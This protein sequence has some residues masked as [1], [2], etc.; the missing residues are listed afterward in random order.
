[1]CSVDPPDLSHP[2]PCPF[3]GPVPY[4]EK[5]RHLFRG[6][7]SDLRILEAKIEQRLVLLTGPS[8]V[9]KSSLLSAAL[10]P[11]LRIRRHQDVKGGGDE[12]PPILLL[13]SWAGG[14]PQ[15]DDTLLDGIR[16]AV[17]AFSQ[18]LDHDDQ[19]A[20]PG[21]TSEERP[22]YSREERQTFRDDLESLRQIAA[23]GSISELLRRVRNSPAGRLT[24]I[25]DQ[26]EE[27]LQGSRDFSQRLQE[28]VA[29]LYE[30]SVVEVVLSYRE[31]ARERLSHLSGRIKDRLDRQQVFLLP[32]PAA[33]VEQALREVITGTD[34]GGSIDP[35]EDRELS[36]LG[37]LID[38]VNDDEYGGVDLLTLQALLIDI[39][40]T[41]D[42][43]QPF[44]LDRAALTSLLGRLGVGE[45]RVELRT[46]E[47]RAAIGKRAA[48]HAL[49]RYLD[50]DIFPLPPLVTRDGDGLETAVA[51][52][53]DWLRAGLARDQLKVNDPYLVLQRRRAAARLAPYLSS[54][55]FKVPQQVGPLVARGWAA[56]W[57]VL[58]TNPR[59]VE[60]A[61]EGW[62]GDE[63]S[64]ELLARVF[65]QSD[66][67]GTAPPDA[68]AFSGPAYRLARNGQFR[69][70]DAADAL[71]TFSRAALLRLVDHNVVKMS[72]RNNVP[73]F[74]L[75]HDRFGKALSDW[76]QL[77]R[78]DPIDPLAAV[79]APRGQVFQ[80]ERLAGDVEDA[81]WLGCW[82]GPT[83]DV[84]R[85]GIDRS[86]LV[87][88]LEERTEWEN[89]PRSQVEV[90]DTVFSDCNFSGTIFQ[91]CA[92]TG[93]RLERCDLR[94]LMLR[95]CT[96][97]EGTVL[98]AE[99]SN[100]DALCFLGGTF[101]GL[102]IRGGT[103]LTLA[104]VGRPGQ[105]L[106]CKRLILEQVTFD[107]LA[108][109]NV[110]VVGSFRAVGCTFRLSDLRGLRPV[111]HGKIEFENCTFRMSDLGELR[112]LTKR[113]TFDDRCRFWPEQ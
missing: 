50:T 95:D 62:R 81:C 79:T 36:S 92:F 70:L 83:K 32:A 25:L 103:Y 43:G 88:T 82:I 45:E 47:G 106:V 104:I 94:S 18:L 52:A 30:S 102:T 26:F 61:L 46:P 37:E 96:F 73:T 98:Q 21:G 59:V 53:I 112:T 22:C 110:E 28:I 3:V 78:D 19:L 99:A 23:S 58:G 51:G 75:V 4:A 42:H 16:R 11:R 10:V 49:V 13:R 60:Q 86:L 68:T 65:P 14:L 101:D 48:R 76:A 44:R 100:A 89:H 63:Q 5:D 29:R 12:T 34:V 91:S 57:D 69:R 27:L 66:P 108:I 87:D 20:G 72:E 74:E 39:C 93:A 54:G 6:R 64:T 97:D 85:L 41:G 55:T 111:G 8:G 1:M 17:D 31:E 56:E 7:S 84:Q 80:W 38:W 109:A 2:Y 71:L 77:T 33:D 15:P 113:V 90:T 40:R 24:L 67:D 107:Q 35:D 9:G 105:P